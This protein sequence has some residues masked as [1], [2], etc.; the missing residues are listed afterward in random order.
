LVKRFLIWLI[1]LALALAGCSGKKQEPAPVPEAP[2]NTDYAL[3]P[4]PDAKV[5]DLT[6]PQV[7]E[8]S[9]GGFSITLPIGW[10]GSDTDE[11]AIAKFSSEIAKASPDL[12]SRVDALGRAA[13]SEDGVLMAF[14]MRPNQNEDA[15]AENLFVFAAPLDAAEPSAWEKKAANDARAVAQDV[16]TSRSTT[17]IDG[18]PVTVLKVEFS[19]KE[20]PNLE[21]VNRS[22][23][24]QR[25]NKLYHFRFSTLA[26]RAKESEQQEL[27][28][29]GTVVWPDE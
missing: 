26:T 2:P 1:L 10:Q 22:Y 29:L 4:P 28:T 6:Q 12:S 23:F 11:S 13:R 5:I 9:T 24:V 20:N 19:P 25:N 21:I 18:R 8:S 16:K 27:D 15:F 14:D 17:R 7:V 3:P